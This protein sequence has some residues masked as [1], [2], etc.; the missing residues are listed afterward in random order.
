[1]LTNL[2]ARD[3]SREEGEAKSRGHHPTIGAEIVNCSFALHG[4]TIVSDEK[5]ES[6]TRDRKK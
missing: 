4:R 6:E 3:R 2:L 1:M 5:N